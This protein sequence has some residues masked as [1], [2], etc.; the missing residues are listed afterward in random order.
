MNQSLIA[1]CAIVLTVAFANVAHSQATITA[2]DPTNPPANSCTNT[3]YTVSGTLANTNYGFSGPVTVVTGFSIAITLDYYSGFAPM[4]GLTPFSEDV[5]LGILPE[6]TYAITTTANVDGMLSSVD[7]GSF[8]VE[9]CCT[10]SVN[11]GADSVICD[12]A[13]LLL[14]ATTIGATY[15]W[16]NGSSNATFIADATGIYWVEVSDS[17]GCVYTDSITVTLVNCSLS[18][19][20]N[21]SKESF[22]MYP[23]PADNSFQISELTDDTTVS[24]FTLTGEQVEYNWVSTTIDVS[25]LSAGV[26]IVR[27]EK[28]GSFRSE[29][30]MIQ[31]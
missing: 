6:G 1:I 11:L 23:N 3:L 21:S 7:T 22:T 26:Y 15:N 28:N 4:P 12:T 24:I 16:Q 19:P 9:T 29:R 13:T 17:I 30:L 25:E 10:G 31:K 2:S 18:L 5:P 20:Q 8:Y 14:D 27:L